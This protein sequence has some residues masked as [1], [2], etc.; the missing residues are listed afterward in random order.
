MAV[1]SV[2][3]AVHG[4]ALVPTASGWEDLAQ[5]ARAHH[6][7]ASTGSSEPLAWSNAV[8]AGR[9]TDPGITAREVA[10]TVTLETDRATLTASASQ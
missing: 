2:T 7:R 3:D 5:Q 1:F 4:T 6:R 9:I 10:A 8:E